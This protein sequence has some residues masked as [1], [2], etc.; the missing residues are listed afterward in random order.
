VLTARDAL[1]SRP[2][3]VLVAG[4]SGSGKTT[5]AEL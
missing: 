3:R 2:T 4:T 5:L 1:G